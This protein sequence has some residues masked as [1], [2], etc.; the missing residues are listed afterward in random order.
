MN[1]RRASMTEISK[2]T[3][4]ACEECDLLVAVPEVRE[5]ERAECPRCGHLLT[6]RPRQGFERALSFALA[7]C[8]FFVISLSF[9]F[10]SFSSSGI[11]NV[12]TLPE[13]SIAIYRQH[14]AILAAIVFV[15][16]IA[17]PIALLVAVIALTLPLVQG[18]RASWLPQAAKLMFQL[19][20]WAMVEVFVIGAIVSLV[21][22]AHLATVVLGL[23]FW[24]YIIFAICLT[25]AISGLDRMQ[26]WLAI[27][28]NR[29]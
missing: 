13:A 1:D 27:E 18:L 14:D 26:V 9:P 7:G 17:L 11:E 21:K 24:A 5:G 15:A 19:N 6:Q 10:L 22:I 2:Q 23:S 16:I 25:A 12:M 3:H 29:T 8:V 28:A 4:T 20:D